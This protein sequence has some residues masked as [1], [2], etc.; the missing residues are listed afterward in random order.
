MLLLLIHSFLRRPVHPL[1]KSW[2]LPVCRILCNYWETLRGKA[3]KSLCFRLRS[4][5]ISRVNKN[6][7]IWAALL[8]GSA[9]LALGDR[10][11]P[12][13]RGEVHWEWQPKPLLPVI[14]T[15][16]RTD[17][18]QNC[19]HVIQCDVPRYHIVVSGLKGPGPSL[20]CYCSYSLLSHLLSS[21]HVSTQ[22]QFFPVPS[23]DCVWSGTYKNDWSQRGMAEGQ[24]GPNEVFQEYPSVLESFPL[25]KVAFQ[26]RE[27]AMTAAITS[28]LIL[29][30]K[31]WC[32]VIFQ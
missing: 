9:Q 16:V 4:G 20:G 28:N 25:W 3:S 31:P 11:T 26:T 13:A 1:Y 15:W 6:C 27:C 22:T 8:S 12:G 17:F 19:P 7:D 23:Q 30:T 10:R 32:I 24:W 29:L 2:T 18:L 5:V 14:V 21:P